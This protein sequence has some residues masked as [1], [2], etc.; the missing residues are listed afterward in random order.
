MATS[1]PRTLFSLRLR[2]R[3]RLNLNLPPPHPEEYP[4]SSNSMSYHHGRPRAQD[5]QGVQ[6]RQEQAPALQPEACTGCGGSSG[7]EAA[8]AAARR[9]FIHNSDAQS[10]YQTVKEITAHPLWVTYSPAARAML[11]HT[12]WQDIQT[13]RAWQKQLRTK[14]PPSAQRLRW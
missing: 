13:Y 6:G 12:L 8:A 3:L 7:E 4:R 9:H 1:W 2:L 5:A 11:A 10:Y 14:A